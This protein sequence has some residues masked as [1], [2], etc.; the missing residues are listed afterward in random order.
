MT[1]QNHGYKEDK[2][3]LESTTS[4][5]GVAVQI[6]QYVYQIYGCSECLI[7]GNDRDNDDYAWITA[8]VAYLIAFYS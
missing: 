7:N 4:N 3:K 1:I 5:H 2:N 6:K 8:N